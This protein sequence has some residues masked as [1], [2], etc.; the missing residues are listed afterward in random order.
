VSFV[1]NILFKF[2]IKEKICYKI[3]I[4]NT[5]LT[6]G[7]NYW[8]IPLIKTKVNRVTFTKFFSYECK[9]FVLSS[10]DTKICTKVHEHIIFGDIKILYI[11]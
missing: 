9:V 6:N 5:K 4:Q 3:S 1:H 11:W 2:K 7:K 10:T 8:Q